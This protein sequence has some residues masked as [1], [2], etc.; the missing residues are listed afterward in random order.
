MHR[1]RPPS[2]RPLSPGLSF[3]VC[4]RVTFLSVQ[5]FISHSCPTRRFSPLAKHCPGYWILLV[6]R[7]STGRLV[8][9]CMSLSRLAHSVCVTP[10]R[11]RQ[12]RASHY[13]ARVGDSQDIESRLTLLPLTDPGAPSQQDPNNGAVPAIPLKPVKPQLPGKSSTSVKG[14]CRNGMCD[15]VILMSHPDEPYW[16]LTATTCADAPSYLCAQE[17]GPTY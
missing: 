12:R 17:C 15:E 16:A 11:K 9:A 6:C 1:H 3:Q 14:L 7:Q 5:R 13:T 10:C 4:F 2:M 8:L